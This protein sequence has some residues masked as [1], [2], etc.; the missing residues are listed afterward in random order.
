MLTRRH[1]GCERS[2]K[3]LSARDERTR[4]QLNVLPEPAGGLVWRVPRRGRTRRAFT[5]GVSPNPDPAW[6]TQQA[7]NASWRMAE[8]GLPARFLLLDHDAKYTTLQGENDGGEWVSQ[9]VGQGRQ[10]LVCR[11]G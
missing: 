1:P 6:V 9:L 8:W 4:R 10:R 7:R 2:S 5:A 11:R 3:R